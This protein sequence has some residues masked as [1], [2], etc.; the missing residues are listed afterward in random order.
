MERF[1]GCGVNPCMMETL[2]HWRD[3]L[4]RALGLEITWADLRSLALQLAIALLAFLLAKGIRRLTRAVTDRL[5]ERLDPRLRPARLMAALRPLVVPLLW[6]GLLA[7][8]TRSAGLFGLATTALGSAATLVALWIVIRATSV[9]VRDPVLARSIAA[10]AWVIAALDILG[11][12]GVVAGALDSF[13]ISFGALRLSALLL[14]KGAIL[15]GI[16]LWL[17]FTAADLVQRRIARLNGF[18]PSMQ[19]LIAKLVKIALVTLAILMA[20]NGVGID[21]TALAVFGGAIGLG[22][23]FGLQKVVS[24]LVSGII[25]LLDRSIKPGDIIEIE[26]TFGWITSLG[27]RYVSVRSRDGKEYLIPNEDL[28]THRVTN[29][30]YS[31]RLVRLDVEFAVAYDSD[32]HQVRAL[33]VAAAAGVARVL[34]K[35]EPVCHV[36]G[37]GDS[38]VGLVLRFWIDDPTNGVVNVKGAVYLALWDALKA[39]GITLPFPQ[40]EVRLLGAAPG[41]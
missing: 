29:W 32:L 41:G 33:A 17:A 7:L 14:I 16:L 11:L 18:S 28:I 25:L 10:A 12:L 22:L 40:R 20:L 1:A 15:L 34:P 27:A 37:F 26:K 4:A 19:V 23:G 36:T 9:L 38:A 39:H 6:W 3:W 30:S 5:V 21:L 13:A 8:A 2:A 24:N 31:S 35:P